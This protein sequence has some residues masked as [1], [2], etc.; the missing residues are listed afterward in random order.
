M[1]TL[2]IA[3]NVIVIVTRVVA[4]LVSWNTTTIAF[5]GVVWHTL[6]ITGL[7]DCNALFIAFPMIF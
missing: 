5:K 4:G 2:P 1:K 3:I 7:I 6:S